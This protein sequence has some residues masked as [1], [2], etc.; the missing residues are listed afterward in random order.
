MNK[1]ERFLD[2][3]TARQYGEVVFPLFYEKAGNNL[4]IFSM[5]V[6]VLV[7]FVPFTKYLHQIENTKNHT[8]VKCSMAYNGT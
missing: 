8:Q 1:L 3:L 5:L 2:S 7:Y 4:P 6:A